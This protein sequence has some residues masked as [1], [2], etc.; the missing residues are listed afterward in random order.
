[1]CW[2][3][4]EEYKKDGGP[5]TYMDMELFHKIIEDIKMF[6][7]KTGGKI[8]LMKLYSS[9]EPLLHKNIGDM[10][11][12]IKEAQVCNQLEVTTNG[13]LLSEDIAKRFVDEGLDYLRV[14]IYSVL[15][16]GQKRI[17]KSRISPQKIHDNVATVYNYRIQQSKTL[18]FI[19][20]KMIY[21]D[22]EENNL[23][24]R[25]YSDVSDEQIV[26]KPWNVPKLIEKALDKFYGGEKEGQLAENSYRESSYYKTRKVCRYPFTHMTIRSNG[27]AVVC[28]ADWSRDT[29]FGNVKEQ[30]IEEL[31]NSVKLYNFRVMQIKTKGVNHPICATCELPFNFCPEDDIDDLSIDRLKK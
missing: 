22:D 20:A 27:D 7:D 19:C 16:E 17:T 30:T 31:W 23:F 29:C 6:C 8:K 28:C 12:E 2:Q 25:I 24:K 10:V 13:S 15:P 5:F 14:S 21:T 18:P 3:S 9:G 11:H 1:M 26:E 4:S